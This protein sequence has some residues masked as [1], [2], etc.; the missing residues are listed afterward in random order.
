VK[1]NISS[2][3]VKS[4]WYLAIVLAVPACAGSESSK[5]PGPAGEVREK[6]PLSDAT[7]LIIRHAEKPEFGVGL[8]AEGKARARAYVEYFQQLRL[9]GKPVQLDYL[10]AADD[11][12]H[13]QRCRLTLEPLAEALGLRPDTRFQ[14]RQF[15]ELAGELESRPHGKTILICWHHGEIPALLRAL[16]AE[17]KRLLPHGEWP[18]Q[19]FGW[20]LKLRYDEQGHLIPSQCRRIKERLLAEE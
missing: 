4:A 5:E 14:S 1:L 20:L 15:L 11:S 18:N 12:E 19:Q 10:A 2:A 16:G 8:S 3:W 7:I 17:P 6:A 13:S 9:E